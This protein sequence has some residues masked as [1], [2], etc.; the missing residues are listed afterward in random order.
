M[1]TANAGNVFL[2]GH[3]ILLH[4][5]QSGYD[6]LILDYLR[7]GEESRADYTVG[8][9]QASVGSPITRWNAAGY[10]DVVT[11]NLDTIGS[12]GEFAT[13]LAGVDA[14]AY[15][16]APAHTP[17]D[18][19][20]INSYSAEIE[21][22]FNAGGDIFANSD[23]GKPTYYDFLP[24]GA[25]TSGT[26]LSGST[27]FVATAEGTAQIGMDASQMNGRPTHNAFVDFD[28]A[29]TVMERRF[30]ALTGSVVSIGLRGGTIVDDIIIV[31]DTDDDGGTDGGTA[32]PEP[33][34]LSLL[35]AALVAFG[36]VRRRRRG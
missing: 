33:G 29:F 10:T 26:A 20:E 23:I 34:S 32:L 8:F 31:D 9:I 21:S 12:A 13:A 5:G 16:W 1:S 22:W 28:P 17:G 2:T 18:V 19:A 4:G 3:D 30:D 27:G 15:A 11:I 7:D 14:I 6:V 35:G 25:T 36:A 24:P